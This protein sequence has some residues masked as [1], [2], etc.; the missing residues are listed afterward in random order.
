M[1]IVL[2]LIQLPIEIVLGVMEMLM[3][4]LKKLQML[5]SLKILFIL[6]RGLIIGLLVLTMQRLL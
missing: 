3:I 2:I 1:E 5:L 6:G 4:P